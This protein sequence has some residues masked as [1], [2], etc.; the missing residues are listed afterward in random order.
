MQGSVEGST[1]KTKENGITLEYDSIKFRIQACGKGVFK[2]EKRFDKEADAAEYLAGL[3]SGASAW[4]GDAVESGGT[5]EGG[6]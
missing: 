3:F 6:L 2:V 5:V 4:P 1:S